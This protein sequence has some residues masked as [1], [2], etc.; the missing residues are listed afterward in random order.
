MNPSRRTTLQL[1]GGAGLYGALAAISLLRPGSAAAQAFDPGAF[2][3]SGV[4]ATLKALGAEGAAE[5]KD[6]VIVAPD[7]AENGAVVPVAIRSSL[8]KTQMMA[9]LVEKN[10]NALAGA[11]ELLEG[12]DPEVSMRIKMGQ[13]SD[14][15]ALVKADG[16][17]YLARK[18]VK[19]TLGGCGG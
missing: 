8:P 14:V 9:L 3:T 17:F 15:V 4:A 18:E 13:T 19:V 6:V 5:S 11:Y 12:A 2:K 7:I 16:R 10:P 1:A